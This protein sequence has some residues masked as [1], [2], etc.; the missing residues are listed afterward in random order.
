MVPESSFFAFPHSF[1]SQ[2]TDQ[3]KFAIAMFNLGQLYLSSDE[4]EVDL[5]KALTCAFHTV[6]RLPNPSDTAVLNRVR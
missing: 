2:K 1:A 5:Q 4:V 6:R 3:A